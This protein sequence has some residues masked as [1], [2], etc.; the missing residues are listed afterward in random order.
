MLGTLK[1]FLAKVTA[2]QPVNHNTDHDILLAVCALFVELARIDENFTN[3]E[4]DTILEILENR[5]GLSREHGSA[6]IAEAG[7]ELDHSVDLWQFAK[8]IN[9]QYAIPERIEIAE[10]LWRIVYVDDKM[11]RYE[12]HLM[13]KLGKILRLTH[14]Q[15][16]EAKLKV[17]HPE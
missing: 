5:Y 7:K 15:L 17:L 6:L 13:D 1:Q 16:I 11:N 2:G 14:E 8:V 4:M 10:M 9:E 12:H 3:Q